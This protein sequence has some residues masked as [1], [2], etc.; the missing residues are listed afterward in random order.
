MVLAD[1]SH[2][3]SY[4]AVLGPHYKIKIFIIFLPQHHQES[5]NQP[6]TKCVLV[7]QA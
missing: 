3:I 1:L 4:I 7:S 5:S 2:D 6:S